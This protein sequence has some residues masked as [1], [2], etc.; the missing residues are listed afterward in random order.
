MRTLLIGDSLT[1]WND[2]QEVVGTH[3]NHGVP[4]DTT[5]GLLLRLQRSLSAKPDRVIMMIGTNDLLMH[6]PPERVKQNYSQLLNELLEIEHLYILYV[7]PVENTPYTETV[8]ETIMAL[9]FWLREQQWKYGFVYV[10]L[11]GELSGGMGI[12]PEYTDDGVHLSDAGY[13]VWERVLKEALE[14]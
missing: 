7:P 6:T 13:K 14:E 10:D 5:D 8:Y 12:K 1:A 2:W 4:G 3:I 9:N 11:H